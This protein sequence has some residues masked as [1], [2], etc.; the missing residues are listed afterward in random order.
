MPNRT[1][2]FNLR[3][4]NPHL[5]CN[6]LLQGGQLVAVVRGANAPLISRTVQEQFAKE[7]KVLMGIAER[8]EVSLEKRQR[9]RQTDDD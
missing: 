9:D 6:F 5:S 3:H 2:Q 4:L 7:Q 1:S 8:Q